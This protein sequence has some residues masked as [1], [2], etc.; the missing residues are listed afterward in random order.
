MTRKLPHP[1][2]WYYKSF[3]IDGK[4]PFCKSD[5][6][7]SSLDND[8]V[9]C[10]GYQCYVSVYDCEGSMGDIHEEGSGACKGCNWE[11][12]I[13]CPLERTSIPIT[14]CRETREHTHFCKK[15]KSTEI[16]LASQAELTRD[17]VCVCDDC[18]KGVDFANLKEFEK[19]ES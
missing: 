15:C 9:F 11:T 2:N 4:C 18:D 10:R 6:V 1:F 17:L 7:Y 16:P 14:D 8:V 13:F 3:V 12:N 5:H 19:W